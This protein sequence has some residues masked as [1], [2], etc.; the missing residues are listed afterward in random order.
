MAINVT[1][2]GCVANSNFSIAPTNTAQYWTATPAFPWNIS[3]AV[4]S[5]GDG[6]TSNGLWSSHTYSAAGMYQICLTVTV[7]CGSTSSTCATYSI[8]KMSNAMIQINVISPELVSVGLNE[9]FASGAEVLVYPNPG[10]GLFN[11]EVQGNN[12]DVLQVKVYN[13]Q[14]GLVAD[15]NLGKQD[16]SPSQLDLQD[17][18]PGIYLIQINEGHTVQQKKLIITKD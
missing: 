4:W 2:T 3:N 11:L 10:N 12:A 6:S 1:G 7:S 5:W 8:S 15:K 9:S 16:G 18:A 17:L 13:L 14:G